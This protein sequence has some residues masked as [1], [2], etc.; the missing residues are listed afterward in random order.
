MLTPEAAG[1]SANVQVKWTHN[2]GEMPW[3]R[4][5]PSSDVGFLFRVGHEYGINAFFI[6]FINLYQVNLLSCAVTLSI[7]IVS[8][9]NAFFIFQFITAPFQV[10]T[11]YLPPDWCWISHMVA[12]LFG[13]AWL[14]VSPNQ[15][16]YML[17]T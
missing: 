12:Y 10:G 11:L 17:Y 13:E 16:Y 7:L 5:D 9:E 2:S 3:N 8:V 15:F 1:I 4:G 6:S 14:G